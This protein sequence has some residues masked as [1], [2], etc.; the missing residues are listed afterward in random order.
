MKLEL[1][2][3][4]FESSRA[5]GKLYIDGTYFCDT[6][7][8][9]FRGLTS[10]M[11]LETILD[12]KVYGATAIPSG[13][14]KV[15]LDVVSPKFSKYPF[16]QSVCQGKLPRLLDVKG[17]DGILIHVA[18]GPKADKL[19][20]GCIGVGELSKEGYLINGK[21]TFKRLYSELIKDKDNIII[22]ISQYGHIIK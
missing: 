4:S 19:V 12:Q 21:E 18:E 22:E 5:L 3:E 7:E 6:L 16:Y 17:F 2:R 14:Y 10:D 1:I 8:D 13:T 11:S 20:K 15:T 9:R